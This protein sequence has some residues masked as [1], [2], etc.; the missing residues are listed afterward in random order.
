[1]R[2]AP[3]QVVILAVV[4]VPLVT[5][6]DGGTGVDEMGGAPCSASGLASPDVGASHGL[7]R[8]GDVA[9]PAV[10]AFRLDTL[11]DPPRSLRLV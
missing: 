3:A 11:D 7:V 8:V 5:A 9:S 2:R 10:V 4:A 6:I 1:M